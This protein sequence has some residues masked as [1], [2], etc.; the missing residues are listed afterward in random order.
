MIENLISKNLLEKSIIEDKEIFHLNTPISL[1]IGD[2][3]I[4]SLQKEYLKDKEIGGYI[5]FKIKETYLEAVE[6]KFIENK[7][8]TPER[9]YVINT[10]EHKTA[11]KEAFQNE[12]LPFRF[13]THPTIGSNPIMEISKYLRQLNTSKKDKEASYN[14][15]HSVDEKELIL[16]DILVVENDYSMGG[17][18]VGFYNGLV[19]PNDFNDEKSKSN[20]EL[21]K[22]SVNTVVELWDSSSTQAKLLFGVGIVAAAALLYKMRKNSIGILIIVALLA[23]QIPL[24]TREENIYFGVTK[25]GSLI[26]KIPKIS[27]DE[28]ENNINLFKEMIERKKLKK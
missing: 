23:V 17:M 22:K 11:E 24:V 19:T 12:L 18:F 28:I 14:K 5:N 21:A 3:I 15:I 2:K 7:S 16:P 10:P 26:I 20:E 25:G 27:Q 8:K 13:H 9:S 6:V 4:S 1:Q